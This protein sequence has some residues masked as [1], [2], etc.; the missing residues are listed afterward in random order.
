MT[1]VFICLQVLSAHGVH[2]PVDLSSWKEEDVRR[3]VERF[4]AIRFPMVLLLN[5]GDMSGAT[6]KNIEAICKIVPEDRVVVGSALSEVELR[7]LAKENKIYYPIGEDT[8]YTAE[9]LEDPLLSGSVPEG[10][11]LKELDEKTKKM[12]DKLQGRLMLRFGSTGVWTALQ[13]AIGL[14]E[15]VVA[16]PV[17]NITNLIATPGKGDILGTAVV[18]QK[19][20]TPRNVAAAISTEM[21][22]VVGEFPWIVVFSWPGLCLWTFNCFVAVA[23][24]MMAGLRIVV[25]RR[26]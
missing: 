25:W 17:S 2:D 1:P 15:P 13:T 6:G 18:L 23:A 12:L 22:R 21:V 5:K 19:G 3:L 8:W 4:I 9:D 10:V 26:R 14:L 11:K 20:A 7:K 16:Y 24:M